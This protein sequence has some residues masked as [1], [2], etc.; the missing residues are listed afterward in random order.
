M[1][2]NPLFYGMYIDKNTL[3]EEQITVPVKNY[4]N[5]DGDNLIPILYYRDS[6]NCKGLKKIVDVNIIKNNQNENDNGFTKFFN[7]YKDVFDS[8]IFD[9]I[10]TEG[11]NSFEKVKLLYNSYISNYYDE[12]YKN[13]E[14]FKNLN[15]TE[16]QFYNLYYDCLD[17]TLYYYINIEYE[18]E[19]KNVPLI[20]LSELINDMLNYMDDAIDNPHNDIKLLNYIGHD[21]ILAGLQ[22]ILD[23]P[24]DVPPKL[25]NFTSN[26]LFLLCKI[27]DN[28]NEVDKNYEVRYFYNDQLS[29]VKNYE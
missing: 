4:K 19:A 29:L 24:F 21:S 3:I 11:K 7:T 20:I 10:I 2:S 9:E 23:K 17:I 26:Q 25:M 1:S 8:F 5:Y 12:R 6:N 15:Y 22:I 27:S 18:C 13:I 16:E 14:I 28:E